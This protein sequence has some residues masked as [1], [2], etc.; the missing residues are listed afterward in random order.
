[1]MT[2]QNRSEKAGTIKTAWCLRTYDVWGNAKDG[3]QVNDSYSAG[4]VELRIPATRHNVGMAGEFVSAT[5][6]DRQ[7]KRLF[8]TR[9]RIDTDGDDMLIMV[10]RQRDGY[11]IGEMV[12]TS[13]ESLSPVRELEVSA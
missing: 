10:N 2:N 1:M 5:P 11:P 8:G 12:C 3:Y 7:I 4:Q 9:S 6:T 13:H